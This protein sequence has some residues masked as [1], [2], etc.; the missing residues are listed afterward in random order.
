MGSFLNIIGYVVVG[1]CLLSVSLIVVSLLGLFRNLPAV[2]NFVRRV[3]GWLMV[4]TL[5]LYQPILVYLQPLIL[6]NVGIDLLQIPARI[7]ASILLSFALLLFIYFTA[8]WQIS[9]LGAGIAFLHGFSVGLIW[10]AIGASDGLH[11]G[12]K[13]E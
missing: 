13:L 11:I 3:L 12:E 4:L 8:G 1:T 7:A 10:E 9:T 2:F 6:R 5:S